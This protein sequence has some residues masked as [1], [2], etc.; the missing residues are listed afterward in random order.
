ML[1]DYVN[2]HKDT[3]T[4][5]EVIRDIK[6]KSGL[7]VIAKGIMCAEDALLA[8]EY[9]ADAIQVSNHGARHLDTA[10]AAIEV[11]AE[12]TDALKGKNID[13]YFDGGIRRGSDV[14]KALALGAKCVF[15]G[16]PILWALAADG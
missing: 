5:W 4:G 16:R 15:L 13:I 14:L 11:L 1:T 9:G 8:Y 10:P 12:I 2:K 7:P 6:K 3:H